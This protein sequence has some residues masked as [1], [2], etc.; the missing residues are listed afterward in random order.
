M[1]RALLSPADCGVGRISSLQELRPREGEGCPR[2]V[3]SLALSPVC[4]PW[5]GPCCSVTLPF[6]YSLKVNLMP[7]ISYSHQRA[8]GLTT[9]SLVSS[10][11]LGKG[12]QDGD[13][14]FP[15]PAR[16]P[17]STGVPTHLHLP[18]LCDS[19]SAGYEEGPCKNIFH[20]RVVTNLECLPILLQVQT[21]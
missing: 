9:K 16:G 18:V 6:C 15:T 10:Q 13:A 11:Q 7:L 2:H 14:G 17:A 3:Q 8:Y 19:R 1:C 21:F 4:L 5:A 20:P 12:S